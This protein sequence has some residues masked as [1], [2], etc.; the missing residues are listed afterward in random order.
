MRNAAHVHAQSSAGSQGLA[1]TSLTGARRPAWCA[2][3]CRA[4]SLKSAPVFVLDRTM[5]LWVPACQ[6]PQD[7]GS[8]SLVGAVVV[9]ITAGY[10]GKRVVFEKAHQLGAR[11]VVLDAPDRWARD[12]ALSTTDPERARTRAFST[13]ARPSAPCPPCA[14]GPGSWS[15]RA[16]LPSSCPWTFRTLP[17]PSTGASRS[18]LLPTCAAHIWAAQSSLWWRKCCSTSRDPAPRLRGTSSLALPAAPVAANGAESPAASAPAAPRR[19]SATR[20][21]CCGRAVALPMVTMGRCAPSPPFASSWSRWPRAWPSAWACRTTRPPPWTLRGTRCEL[22][23]AAAC[24]VH[25]RP[26]ASLRGCVPCTSMGVGRE[27]DKP[28]DGVYVHLASTEWATARVMQ[29]GSAARQI[30]SSDQSKAPAQTR[31]SVT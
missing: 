30:T 9:F 22:V 19:P 24:R 15:T 12:P 3:Q 23:C 5:V 25:C 13:H 21:H 20:Q 2:D 6:R 4:P 14:A 1:K 28:E 18:V 8:A 26:S 10:Q 31:A 27:R 11:S 16:R 29:E 7:G 17:P